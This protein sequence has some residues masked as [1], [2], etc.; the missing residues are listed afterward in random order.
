MN[1]SAIYHRSALTDC[2]A[3]DKDTAVVNLRTDKDITA[4]NLI[5]EDPYAYGLSGQ[6]NWYGVPRAMAVKRELKPPVM[7]FFT[8]SPNPPV[9]GYLR[10]GKL[11]LACTNSFITE[12]IN[13]P[14]VLQVV[15]RKT[16]A[17]LGK[18]ITV[19]AVDQ[20]AAK[21]NS[22]QIRRLLQ[23]GRDHADVIH[24]KEND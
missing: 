2:Y 18:P 24:I 22:D 8:P 15:A 20:S 10:D 19:V 12:Q 11:I 4:V 3:L 1:R 17:V 21:E 7:G 6:F 16:A 9:K 14:E 23:F 13:K 5:W